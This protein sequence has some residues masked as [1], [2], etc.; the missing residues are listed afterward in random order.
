MPI[1]DR[2]SAIALLPRWLQRTGDHRKTAAAFELLLRPYLDAPATR[3]AARVAVAR[4][5]LVAGDNERVLELVRQAQGDDPT[6][7]DPVLMALEL[8]KLS[9]AEP[10]VTRYLALPGAKA[11]VRQAFARELAQAQRFDESVAQIERVTRDNPQLAAPW[12]SLGALRLELRQPKA[13]ETALLRYLDLQ[14]GAPRA[15]DDEDGAEGHPSN[16]RNQAWLL[17]AQ[18]AELQGDL[19]KAAD[20][21]AKVDQPQRAL[22]VLTRRASLLARQGNIQAA[23]ELL[24]RDVQRDPDDL[25]ARLLAEAQVMRDVKRWAEAREALVEANQRFPDDVDLLYEQ[26]MVEERLEHGAEME[27]LLR[28]VIALKPDHAQSYNALGYS[29]ADRRER[30]PEARELIKQA[31]ALTP[32]DPFITDSLGWVEFRLGNKAEALKLL[33]QA[34]AARPDAEIAAHLGE[35]LW[36]GGQRD[37][38]RNIWREAKGRDGDNEVLNE[39]LSRLKAGL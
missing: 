8:P 4:A 6:A 37:E 16:N 13:A 7:V 1:V 33:K 34:Y 10:L 12:L 27:R 20:W 19:P 32:D 24:R 15:A 39:T 31:L 28:K 30:L 3:T 25:R 26:A 21:L 14:G 35:V 22:E 23:R 29:L 36:N 5:W 11:E 2:P 9:E 18:A 38:A 17:L